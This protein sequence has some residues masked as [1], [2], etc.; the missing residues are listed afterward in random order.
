MKPRICFDIDGVIATGTV[1]TVYSDDA[2]WAYDKCTPIQKTIDLIRQLDDNG[3]DIVLM[4]A[5]YEEDREKTVSW[6]KRHQ[7]P[8]KKLVM[9]K[10]NADLYIDDK[11]YP[12]PFVPDSVSHYEKIMLEVKRHAGRR[13]VD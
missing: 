10:P 13:R 2:G 1:E 4:T 5:R 11:N 3:C 6:L 8:Y 12:E 9:G 7:I